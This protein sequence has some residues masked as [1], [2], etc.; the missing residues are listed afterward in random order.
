MPDSNIPRNNIEEIISKFDLEPDSRAI[1]VEGITDQNFFE[2]FIEE[3][4]LKNVAVN[5]IEWFD[6][7]N[8]FDDN[9]ELIRNNKEKVVFLSNCFKN[10]L[11][12]FNEN[13]MFIVDKDFDKLIFRTYDNDYIFTTDYNSIELY[14]FNKKFLE[15]YFKVVLHGF[16]ISSLDTLKK[17]STILQELF[18]IQFVVKSYNAD[19]EMIRLNN[20]CEIK[21]NGEIKFDFEDYLTRLLNKNKMLKL[22]KNIIDV[23]SESKIL[24]EEEIR[25]QICGHMFFDLL[26]L[27]INKIKNNIDLKLASFQRTIFLTVD[28]KDLCKEPLFAKLIKTYS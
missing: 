18:I 20:S 23:I 8:H 15:K 17:L 24:F 1:F 2:Q 19:I 25:N 3:N 26:Y 5:L 14:L 10:K 4:N 11:S 28:Y 6:F 21:K 7:S 27:Y 22:K 12:V 16:P 9:P 13:I